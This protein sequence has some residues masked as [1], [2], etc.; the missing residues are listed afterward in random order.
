MKKEYD[1]TKLKTKR[2]GPLPAFHVAAGRPIKAC[3][4][5]GSDQIKRRKSLLDLRGKIA[6]APDYDAQA[7]REQDS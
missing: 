7:T 3:F 6:F 4:I 5:A 2:R 1:V